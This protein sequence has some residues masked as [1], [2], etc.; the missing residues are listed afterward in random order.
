MKVT[1]EPAAS[2]SFAMA[3]PEIKNVAFANQRLNREWKAMEAMIRIHCRDQHGSNV[4]RCTE[5]QA[6]LDYANVRL[7]RCRFGA[8][9]P[10]CAN[11]P[12]H[13]YQKARREEVKAVMHY[14]GPRMMW[15]HPVMSLRHWLDGF[16]KA[17][18]A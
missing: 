7:A 13:C 18:E 6:L 5:C 12:V 8:E 16:R 3:A 14:A 1:V 9:K 4:T 15:E 11:C 17:P 2:A 10:T